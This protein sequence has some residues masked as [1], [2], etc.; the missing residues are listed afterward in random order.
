MR[1]RTTTL[2]CLVTLALVAD[3]QAA[4]RYA[5]PNGSGPEPC[6]QQAPCSLKVALGQAKANDEVIIGGGT[7]ATTETQYNETGAE[8]LY[9]HGDF[10]GPAPTIEPSTAD[11]AIALNSK[12]TRLSYI[13]VSRARKEANG[14]YC[15]TDNLVERVRVVVVGEGSKALF[16]LGPCT[17]RDSV[18][19]A[20]GP[21]SI[22]LYYAGP[23]EAP[24]QVVRNLTAIAS[25]PGSKGVDAGCFL[26]FTGNAGIDLRN[27][28]ASGEAADIEA[29]SNAPIAVANS[30]FDKPAGP[31]GTVVVGGGNQSAAPLFVDAAGG[32]FHQ[33]PG[34]PTIDAGAADPLLGASDLDGHGRS[35]GPAPDIGAYEQV[36]P[37]ALVPPA[38]GVIQTL[39]IAPR[40]FRAIK[41]GEGI[42]TARKGAK[43][44]L[45]AKVTYSLSAA[46]EVAFTVERRLSGRRVGKKCVKKTRANKGKKKCPLYKPVKGSFTHTG[47]S[48]RTQ[49]KFS[50]RI[51][52]KSLRPGRYRLVG[53][54]GVTKKTA[55]FRIVK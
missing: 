20:Q 3:A 44:P 10:A 23:P 31:A 53:T 29:D 33:A 13:V 6:G 46:G 8:N 55:A 16:T 1:I 50:G 22:A 52:G 21:G 43:A 17:I 4:Q 54:T 37:Q 48:G 34:S 11:Y 7:Y 26:C 47:Q 39:A 15:G 38:P 40:A 27:T 9:I 24:P 2:A 49:F 35:L 19:V 5:A 42:A 18:A 36:P 51:G 12:G 32:D 14:I 30:N 25:G 41:A 45:G 28:I